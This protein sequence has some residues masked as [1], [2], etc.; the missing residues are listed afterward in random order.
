MKRVATGLA[1]SVQADPELAAQAV[2]M[3]LRSLDASVASSVLLLLTSEFA[4]DPQ[5]RNPS[6]CQGG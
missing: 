5:P 1:S 3:A 2:E 4:H 6:R